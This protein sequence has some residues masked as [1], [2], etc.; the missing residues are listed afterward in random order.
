MPLQGQ[1]CLVWLPNVHD[2]EILCKADVGML[3]PPPPPHLYDR[4][5]IS[6]IHDNIRG[7][8]GGGGEVRRLSDNTL[9][10]LTD[11]IENHN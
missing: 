3:I 4:T 11:T 6:H 1:V 10:T 2:S 8:G 5:N 9:H 7:G